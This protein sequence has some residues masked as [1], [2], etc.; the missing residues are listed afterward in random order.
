MKLPTLAIIQAIDKLE[1]EMSSGPFKADT[2]EYVG[3]NWLIATFGDDRE[4]V[5][6]ILTTD[7]VH[8]SE[9]TSNPEADAAFFALVRNHWPE[10]SA[11]WKETKKGG[12]A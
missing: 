10:I 1:T 5:G 4:G 8:A 6:H 7:R 2:M 12:A 9:A 11:A 3:E